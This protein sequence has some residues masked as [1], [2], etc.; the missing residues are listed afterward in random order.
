MYENQC[1]VQHMKS[2]KLQTHGAY[3]SIY[4]KMQWMILLQL[5]I[6]HFE[7]ALN[8]LFM[9]FHLT[10]RWFLLIFLRIFVLKMSSCS[11]HVV[12][13]WL[14]IAKPLTHFS[15][16][17]PFTNSNSTKYSSK[18][19]CFS[20][21]IFESVFCLSAHKSVIFLMRFSA[22]ALW[23]DLPQFEYFSEL[24]ADTRSWC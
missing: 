24:P 7:F 12:T 13:M 19:L 23:F 1:T 3:S 10:F 18:W 16:K 11:R 14:Q 22:S 15:T 8:T 17:N 20:L 9:G 4:R 2:L 21:Q 5:H 6:V